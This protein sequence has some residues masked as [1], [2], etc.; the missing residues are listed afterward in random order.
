MTEAARKAA[1][2]L[3]RTIADNI[4][5]GAA[6]LRDFEWINGIAECGEEGGYRKYEHDGTARIT[7]TAYS[8][9][10][11]HPFE[12]VDNPQVT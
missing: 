6:A 3:L 4:E 2:E 8:T 9:S 5:S 11:N 12:A 1:V 7:F 10:G